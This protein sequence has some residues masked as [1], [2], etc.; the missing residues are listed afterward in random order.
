MGEETVDTRPSPATS[1][2]DASM[3]IPAQVA[4][5]IGVSRHTMHQP[6]RPPARRLLIPRSGPNTAPKL[7][8]AV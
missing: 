8:G 3:L 6:K 1:A 7:S 5:A 4:Q 2:A